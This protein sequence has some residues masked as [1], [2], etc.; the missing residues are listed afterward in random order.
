MAEPVP[1][2]FMNG[3]SSREVEAV[4][5]WWQ[6]LTPEARRTLKW[7]RA[8][9]PLV[10]LGRFVDAEPG[11]DEASHPSDFYEY[12][13]GHEI[14]LDDGRR[15]HICR[16][17]ER[18]RAAL[19]RGRIHAAFACPLRHENCPLRRLLE[20]RTGRDLRVSLSWHEGEHR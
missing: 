11:D 20:L 1:A 16:A 15:F 3:L 17:H 5:M 10:L 9:P 7:R 14:Y 19:A 4:A 12:L 6:G 2:A 13:V 8:T 18:A